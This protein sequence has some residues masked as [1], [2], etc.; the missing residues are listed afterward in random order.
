MPKQGMEA[1]RRRALVA[2]AIQAIGARGS[3]DVTMR[4]IA[5]AAGVSPALAHHYFGAKE[6]LFLAAMRQLLVDFGRDVRTALAAEPSPR[7]RLSAVIAQ[8][9]GPD[10]FS[11]ATVAAWLA[12]YVRAQSDAQ[13]KRLLRVYSLRLLSNLRHALRPL[14]PAGDV[15][16]IAEGVAALID[17]LYIRRALKGGPPDPVSAIALVEDYLDAQLERAR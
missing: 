13:A 7:G 1:I 10:Q 11:P 16:R 2:A 6:T 12:F 3:L 8:S 4:Q 9:F 5:Q 17:G 15:V 14:V